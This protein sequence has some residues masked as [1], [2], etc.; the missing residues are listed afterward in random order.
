MSLFDDIV[1]A[2]EEKG[3]IPEDRDDPDYDERHQD[4]RDDFNDLFGDDLDHFPSADEIPEEQWADWI[5]FMDEYDLWDE[6]RDQW[7]DYERA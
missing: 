2:A 6:Y 4:L 7:E 3:T 1:D 5:A